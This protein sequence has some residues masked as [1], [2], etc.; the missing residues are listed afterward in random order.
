MKLST[1]LIGS[2][3]TISALAVLLGA[4]SIYWI[5]GLNKSMQYTVNVAAKRQTIAYELYASTTRMQSLDRAIM[6]RSILQQAAGAE[7]NKREYRDVMASVRKLLPEY[8]A[9]IE[10]ETGRRVYDNVRTDMD[11]LFQAHDELVQYMD[12]QQFDQ[13][14]KVADEKV[15]PRAEAIITATN[16]MV[17]LESSRMKS[18]TEGAASKATTAQW[19]SIVFTLICLAVSGV[20]IVIV[21][22]IS[23]TLLHLA[24]AMSSGAEE[25]AA[26]ATQVAAVSQALAQAS[27]EQ[28]AS[29]EE[30]SASGHDLASMTR[31]NVD[32]TQR[33]SASVLET[34]RQLKLANE[35]LGNMVGSMTEINAS[36]KKISKIIRVIDEIAFQ[37]NIL[38]LN[39]AVEAARA[40]EAGM[41]FAVVAD[42]VRNLAQRC[43]QAAQDTAGLIEESIQTV[44]GGSAKLSQV[45]AAIE[46]IAQQAAGV[47]E[48]MTSVNDGSQEQ[49]RHIDQISAAVAQMQKVTQNTAA[50]AEQG[51]AASEEMTQHAESM[52]TSVSEL[53]ILVAGDDGRAFAQHRDR[54]RAQATRK[55]PANGRPAGKAPEQRPSERRELV[56]ASARANERAFPLDDSKFSD[57]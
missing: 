12:R 8:Q 55:A 52:R 39:A 46:G 29:L 27:S 20:V 31:K 32:H 30:T 54:T 53:Q 19:V 3:G 44:D 56:G 1:K 13:V 24:G 35:T 49:S 23:R 34:D 16:E 36:S 9:L 51:A 18:A 2:A 25:V 17:K 6:L 11:Q 45:V 26:A 43:A 57:F 33:A 42:E 22:K 37:T 41:G 48:L 28:A 21:L 4:C 40:G 47:K 10:D 15:M 14:Q 5:N 38:A 7:D 50:S